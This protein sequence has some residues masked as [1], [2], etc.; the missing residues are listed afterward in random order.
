MFAQVTAKN[1]GGVFWD[2]VYINVTLTNT[3]FPRAQDYS[4]LIS[5]HFHLGCGEV[6]FS[7]RTLS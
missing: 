2:T 3:V 6:C 5:A 7:E 1:I 4:A